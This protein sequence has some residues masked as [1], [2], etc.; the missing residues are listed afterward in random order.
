MNNLTLSCWFDHAPLVKRGTQSL[1]SLD[2]RHRHLT[3]GREAYLIFH[4]DS[5][6]NHER[7][8]SALR[9]PEY[10]RMPPMLLALTLPDA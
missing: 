1:P 5:V 9:P 7:S 6:D 4:L 8:I 2:L 3:T 10:L